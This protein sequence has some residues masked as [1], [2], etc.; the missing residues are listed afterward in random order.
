M[1]KSRLHHTTTTLNLSQQSL[2]IDMEIFVHLADVY[3]KNCSK[4]QT[5]KP[6]CRVDG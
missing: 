3:R 5:A 1:T 6:R 4:E 2:H